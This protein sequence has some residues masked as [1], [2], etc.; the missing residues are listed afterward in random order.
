MDDPYFRSLRQGRILDLRNHAGLDGLH[1]VV[2]QSCDVVQPKRELLQLAPLCCLDGPALIRGALKKENPRYP[3]V[4]RGDDPLFADLARIVSVQKIDV[5]NAPVSPGS[6]GNSELEER[7]FGLAVARW[8]GRFAFPDEV[9]P[10]LA[11]VQKRIRD[12]YDKP[13][14]SLA[15]VLRLVSEIRVEA[16]SWS[17]FPLDLTLHVIVLAGTLPTVPDDVEVSTMAPIPGDLNG[18]CGALLDCE[19]PVRLSVLWA[20]FAEALADLCAPRGAALAEE[21]VSTAVASVVGEVWSDDEFPL[22]R[23]RKSEQL[24]VDFLS[25]PVPY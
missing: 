22:S 12:K 15:S 1:V 10:W 9:Q 8:F 16:D 19:D 11:P 6:D 23:V 20:A 5:I 2:S 18:L 3:L 7:E 24:D 21:G 4:L 17:R 14:S 25:E 13:A